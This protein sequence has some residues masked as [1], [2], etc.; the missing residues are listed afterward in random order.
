MQLIA[1]N[2]VP[3]DILCLIVSE[4]HEEILWQ[5]LSALIHM[6]MRGD[7]IPQICIYKVVNEIASHTIMSMSSIYCVDYAAL[8]LLLDSNSFELIFKEKICA[9]L[10]KII[11]L[12]Q[13]RRN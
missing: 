4:Y 7:K 13:K 5:L 11:K 8:S 1:E 12:R 3:N 6:A 9:N 10:R 2:D